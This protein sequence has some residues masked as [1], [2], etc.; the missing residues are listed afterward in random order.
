M[1]IIRKEIYY[2]TKY[3]QN[4]YKSS[5]IDLSRQAKTS[6]P[7]HINFV[8]KLEEDDG[9]TMFLSLKSRNKQF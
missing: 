2:I 1:M 6:I 9:A 5:G 8:R 4:Y 3:H 7:Q